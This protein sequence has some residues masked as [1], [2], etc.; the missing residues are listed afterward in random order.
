MR[1]I[2]LLVFSGLLLAGCSS[3]QWQETSSGIEVNLRGVRGKDPLKLKIDV[4][5][6]NIIHV[7]ASPETRFSK[8]KSLIVADNRDLSIGGFRVGGD[9]DSITVS[10]ARLNVKVSI[11]TGAVVFYDKDYNTILK[12]YGTGGKS[13]KPFSVEG[14]DGYSLYQV[15]ESP[16]DEAFYGLGQHQ[17]DEFNYKG[18][19]E[20][21]FQYNTKVSIPFIV[22]NKNY[23]ILWDNY[24]LTKFGDPRDYSQIDL[25]RLYD[26]N[27]EEGG[28][29]ASYLVDSDPGKV[30]VKRKES[31]IDY[32]N[33]E[34]IRNFPADFPFN[35]STVTWS[36]MIEPVESGLYH[37]K[38]YYAGY[39]K[40]FIDDEAVVAE[41]WR[42]AWNPNTFRFRKEME[43]D[44]KYSIR[45]EW[46][47]DGGVSYLGLKAQSP[48]A[49][50]DQGNLSLWSEMGDRID[51]Y[52]I[53]GDNLDEV[54]SGYR[55]VTG[56]APIMPKWALGYWQSRE[57]Y[58]SQAQLL[59]VVKEYRKRNIPLDNIVLDWSYWPVDS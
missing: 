1:N 33:L 25:F 8:R 40:V 57:R 52:F 42:T 24:S 51:Y 28:L 45:V 35:G 12:E 10:T 14:S 41:R 49:P 7:M 13:F 55:S 44:K 39:I 27:G 3:K 15:F 48:R 36:G 18:L 43:G 37:F 30:F 6:D 17:S 53:K 47:P 21:L 26:E 16:E 5:D 29:T 34:T 32:E 11:E 59:D 19:N 20:E 38:L 9:S 22:S 46:K 56:K 23:G 4:I 58:R 54:I 31:C 2:F 50:E